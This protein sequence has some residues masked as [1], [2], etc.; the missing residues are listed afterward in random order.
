MGEECLIGGTDIDLN[1][2]IAIT[3]LYRA[4]FYLV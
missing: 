3:N 1:M 4:Q 2:T